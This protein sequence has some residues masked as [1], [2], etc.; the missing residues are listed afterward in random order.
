[1]DLDV[2]LSSDQ[3]QAIVFAHYIFCAAR[4]FLFSFF[5]FLSTMFSLKYMGVL[6]DK[7]GYF[8]GII[9]LVLG[10]FISKLIVR[11]MP[12]SNSASKLDDLFQPSE[13]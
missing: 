1:M 10:F 6:Q 9:A 4:E 13:S 11:F 5:I 12:D 3:Y 2:K 7:V 8:S